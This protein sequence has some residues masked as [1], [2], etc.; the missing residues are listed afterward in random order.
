[1]GPH[2]GAVPLLIPMAWAMMAYPIH[3]VVE[4][5]GWNRLARIALGAAH[6]SAVM[7]CAIGAPGRAG[8]S[9]VSSDMRISAA[10]TQPR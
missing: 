4:R 2:L 1:L 5:T 10:M 7:G 9:I 8:S 6:V 3:A